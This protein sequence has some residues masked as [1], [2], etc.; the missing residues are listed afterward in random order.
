MQLSCDRGNFMFLAAKEDAIARNLN[1]PSTLSANGVDLET[2]IEWM[3]HGFN[4]VGCLQ[5][6]FRPRAFPRGYQ[7]LSW[8]ERTR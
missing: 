7:G 5:L 1:F 8:H 4:L 3:T 6:S 2:S